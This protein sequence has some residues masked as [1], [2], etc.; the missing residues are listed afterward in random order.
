LTL[1]FSSRAAIILASMQML[2]L[3]ILVIE[4]STGSH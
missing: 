4:W 3:P 1:N 2:V